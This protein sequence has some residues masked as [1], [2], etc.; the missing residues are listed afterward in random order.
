MADFFAY[1]W[2]VFF[3]SLI[4]NLFIYKNN[5]FIHTYENEVVI[6]INKNTLSTKLKMWGQCS[7]VTNINTRIVYFTFLISFSTKFSAKCFL[8]FSWSFFQRD[9]L[10]PGHVVV[11]TIESR[12]FSIAKVWC[13]MGFVLIYQ[14]LLSGSTFIHPRFVYSFITRF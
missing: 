2:L 6:H 11:V 10:F 13:C 12:N 4:H 8:S 7:A 9:V 14:G 1:S 3:F 5:F